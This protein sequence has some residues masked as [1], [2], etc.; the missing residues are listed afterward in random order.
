MAAI[1]KKTSYFFLNCQKS[2]FRRQ[3]VIPM[4]QAIVKQ[5]R[6]QLA[7]K[8]L[9]Q[10]QRLEMF[11]HFNFSKGGNYY[12]RRG[13]VDIRRGGWVYF[14]PDGMEHAG[15]LILPHRMDEVRQVGG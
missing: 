5:K 6:S 13:R 14:I 7:F 8:D 15:L 4:K 1:G 2:N 3:T 11:N 12:W 10:G 9:F